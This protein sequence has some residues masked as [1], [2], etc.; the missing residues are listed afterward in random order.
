M[1]TQAALVVEDIAAQARLFGEHYRQGFV[2]GA[3]GDIPFRHRDVTLDRRG[4]EKVRH[5]MGTA[6]DGVL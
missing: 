4:E 1:P 6:V 5:G 3:S 2:D